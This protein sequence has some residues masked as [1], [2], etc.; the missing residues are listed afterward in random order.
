M[1]SQFRSFHVGGRHLACIGKM[2]NVYEIV[3]GKH[4][5]KRLLRRPRLRWENNIRIDLRE[6]R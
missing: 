4:E 6:I 3:I 5:R 2:R 1:S